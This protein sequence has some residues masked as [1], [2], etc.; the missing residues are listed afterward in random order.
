MMRPMAMTWKCETGKH[1]IRAAYDEV[2]R[3][4]AQ[5]ARVISTARVLEL[6][7]GTGNLTSLIPACGEL[8]CV[9]L[10]SRMETIAQKKSAHLPNRRFIR[11]EILEVF[12]HEFGTFN[13]VI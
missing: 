10:S 3:W 11:A 1:P 5:E 13:S 6:G 4:V 2:L 12:E 9:D 7:S 8:I